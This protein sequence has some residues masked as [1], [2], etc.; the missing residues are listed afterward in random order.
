MVQPQKS[1]EKHRRFFNGADVF[2]YF[3]PCT[4]FFIFETLTAEN[5]DG[6]RLSSLPLFDVNAIADFFLS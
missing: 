6:K 2:V 1:V 4:R 3:R 5:A